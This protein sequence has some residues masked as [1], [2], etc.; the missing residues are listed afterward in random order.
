MGLQG[1]V[2]ALY[3]RQ[4]LWTTVAWQRGNSGRGNGGGEAVGVDKAAAATV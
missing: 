3:S 2:S 1:G 4:S